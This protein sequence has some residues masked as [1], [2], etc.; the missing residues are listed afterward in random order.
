MIRWDCHFWFIIYACDS[1]I[2]QLSGLF[3]T[4]LE[5]I[6]YDDGDT[7]CIFLVKGSITRCIVVWIDY[8]CRDQRL[9]LVYFTIHIILHSNCMPSLFT[10]QTFHPSPDSVH[11]KMISYIVHSSLALFSQWCSSLLNELGT[12]KIT[13]SFL[14][15]IVGGW[16][17]G[18]WP[19]YETD[20]TKVPYKAT[21]LTDIFVCRLQQQRKKKNKNDSLYCIEGT[22]LANDKEQN[23]PLGLNPL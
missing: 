17:I 14:F 23:Q 2:V 16:W 3:S 9:R 15:L 1:G 13:L 10:G 18:V 20:L 5:S 7:L 6:K 4:G 22:D 11:N 8:F 19:D 21:S 12:K